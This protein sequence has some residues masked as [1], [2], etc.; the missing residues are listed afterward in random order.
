MN[1]QQSLIRTVDVWI[2]KRTFLI[3][4]YVEYYM[5]E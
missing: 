3:F 4:I 5:L 2:W 1:E